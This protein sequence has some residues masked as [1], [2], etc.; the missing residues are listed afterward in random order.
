MID[1]KYGGGGGGETSANHVVHPW[2]HVVLTRWNFK[3]N[4]GLISKEYLTMS[5]VGY[6]MAGRGNTR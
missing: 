4:L 6:S 2:P 1:Q 3:T 5:A